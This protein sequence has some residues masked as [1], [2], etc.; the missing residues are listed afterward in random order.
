VCSESL[1][2]LS[3]TSW[4]WDVCPLVRLNFVGWAFFSAEDVGS[5]GWEIQG[6]RSGWT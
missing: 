4:N 1:W 6:W 3:M 5:K 2:Y